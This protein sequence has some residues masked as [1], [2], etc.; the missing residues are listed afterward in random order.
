[1]FF[2]FFVYI[3]LSHLAWI[4]IMVLVEHVA[5]SSAKRTKAIA[6]I[7][8]MFLPPLAVFVV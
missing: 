2:I 4:N 7:F 1:M 8:F 6:I 3:N 5:P